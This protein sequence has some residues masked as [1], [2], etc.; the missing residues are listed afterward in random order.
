[1]KKVLLIIFILA[2]VGASTAWYLYNKP[3][4]DMNDLNAEYTLSASELFNS[5]NENEDSANAKY[6]GKIVEISGTIRELKS[7]EEGE[8]VIL[9]TD[10]MIFGV[11]CALSSGQESNFKKLKTGTNINIKGECTGISMDVVLVRCIIVDNM[12]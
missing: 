3:V 10:D 8:T 4:A 5:F 11:N 6:L 12:D 9:E 1:M 2:V 7:D